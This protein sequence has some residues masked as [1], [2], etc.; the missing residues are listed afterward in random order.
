MAVVTPT[1]IPD[2]GSSS[3]VSHSASTRGEKRVRLPVSFFSLI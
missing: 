3:P 1:P 2:L